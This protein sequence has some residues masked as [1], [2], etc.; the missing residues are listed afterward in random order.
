[1][2]NYFLAYCILLLPCST[3]SMNYKYAEQYKKAFPLLTA[4]RTNNYSAAQALLESTTAQEL[5]P[6]DKYYA[7]HTAFQQQSA[8]L[9]NLLIK[10]GIQPTII[11][12]LPSITI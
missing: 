11:T 4:I 12:S 9:L 6:A 10:H 8:P 1:M 5:N 7:F 2:K 3:Y